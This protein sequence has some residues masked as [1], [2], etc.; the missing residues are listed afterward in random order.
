MVVSSVCL[1]GDF[2]DERDVMSSCVYWRT[3]RPD[4]IVPLSLGHTLRSSAQVL[5]GLAGGA[6]TASPPVS[7]P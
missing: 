3:C 6:K 1:H 7:T 4:S 5:P 2:W